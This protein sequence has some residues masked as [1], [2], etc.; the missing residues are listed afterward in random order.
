MPTPGSTIKN[1]TAQTH[2]RK[3][4]FGYN[5]TDELRNVLI[6]K[7]ILNN[8]IKYFSKMATVSQL[9]V[10]SVALALYD[11]Q[12]DNPSEG[13]LTIGIVGS[14]KN[15]CTENNYLFYE[16]YIKNNR[17]MARSSLFI[18]TLPTNPLAQTAIV[19]GLRGALFYSHEYSDAD[20][21]ESVCREAKDTLKTTGTDAMLAVSWNSNNEILTSVIR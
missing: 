5:S 15:Q 21:H 14:N 17:I 9:T 19:F 1:F 18:E 8:D 2:L 20:L 12:I 13:N 16:D 6:S 11:A 3:L 10:L 4:A 7:G